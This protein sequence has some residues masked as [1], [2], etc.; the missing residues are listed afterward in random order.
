MNQRGKISNALRRFF[1]YL[2][3]I[4]MRNIKP[5]NRF[6]K[7]ADFLKYSRSKKRFPVILFFNSENF[8]LTDPFDFVSDRKKTVAFNHFQY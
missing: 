3:W 5:K 8:S 4:A 6:Y 1:A 2:T 7:S